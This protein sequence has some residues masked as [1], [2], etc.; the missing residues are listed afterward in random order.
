MK[1]L[2]EVIKV[3]SEVTRIITSGLS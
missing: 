2:E 1:K 3:V